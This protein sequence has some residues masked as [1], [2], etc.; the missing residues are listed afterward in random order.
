MTPEINQASYDRLISLKLEVA[1][2]EAVLFERARKVALALEDIEIDTARFEADEV[3]Y[4]FGGREGQ[5]YEGSF[6]ISMLLSP[7]W[8][9][10][11]ESTRLQKALLAVAW[12]EQCLA[13]QAA[14]LEA[15]ERAELRRLMTKYPEPQHEKSVQAPVQETGR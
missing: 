8:A 4:T 15:A 13:A 3:H 12:R 2:L 5:G 1:D 10:M 6:S 14:E 7:N 11:V 9:F